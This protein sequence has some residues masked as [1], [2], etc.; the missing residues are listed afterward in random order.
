MKN[1]ISEQNIKN[2]LSDS[3][4]FDDTIQ[5][6]TIVQSLKDKNP[7][8]W[9]KCKDQKFYHLESDDGIS[10]TINL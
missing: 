1:L 10:F 9:V 2:L 7:N 4:F 3:L 5:V 8:I 6:K